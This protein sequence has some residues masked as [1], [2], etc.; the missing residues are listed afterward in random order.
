M[1]PARDTGMEGSAAYLGMPKRKYTLYIKYIKNDFDSY[2]LQIIVKRIH[3][4]GIPK[5]G[6]ERLFP[7][8]RL[9]I[10]S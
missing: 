3:L 7:P 5:T 8:I 10:L 2:T 9:S 6:R 1:F 4:P